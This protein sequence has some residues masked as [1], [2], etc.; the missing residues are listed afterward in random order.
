M[1][2]E[3]GKERNQERATACRVGELPVKVIKSGIGLK[4]APILFFVYLVSQA[5]DPASLLSVRRLSS[6]SDQ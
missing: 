3:N 6:K 5:E 4:S 1:D 2:V